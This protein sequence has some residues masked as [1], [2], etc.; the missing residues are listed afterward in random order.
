V[1]ALA[2]TDHDTTDGIDEARE[3]AQLHGIQLICGVEISVTWENRTVHILGLDIDDGNDLL[4]SGLQGLRDCRDS[5]AVEIARKLEKA[6]VADAFDGARKYA[7]G[8]LIGRT[9]FARYLVECGKAKNVSDV[10][11]KFLVQ[12]KPG[13]VSGQWA[14]LEAVVGWIRGAG[15]H[16]VIAHPARYK[17]SATR[18]R[19]LIQEF[20]DAGGSGIEVVSG[21]HGPNDR[22]NMA[23]YAR[24]YDLYASSGSDFHGPENPWIELGRLDG[25][26][27]ICKPIWTLWS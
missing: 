6:G 21:S 22:H 13:H 3:A 26:P 8:N 2:L 16:A 10:F 5:R 9:H 4:Q 11:K 17:M 27:T 19:K 15:G 12:G 18:L 1:D 14:G 23:Q 24:Q 20:K 25:L 7:T